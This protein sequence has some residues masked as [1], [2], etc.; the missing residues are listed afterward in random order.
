MIKNL[1]NLEISKK[2]KKIGFEAETLFYWTKAPKLTKLDK[3]RYIIALANKAD[4]SEEEQMYPAYH[5]GNLIEALPVYIE[6]NEKIYHFVLFKDL[7]GYYATSLKLDCDNIQLDDYI[8]EFY[9]HDK[10][11]TDTASRLLLELIEAG[12]INFKK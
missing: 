2:L 8:F 5:L 4:F 12:I 11:L 6:K 9:D 10:S 7:L 3:D 1:T